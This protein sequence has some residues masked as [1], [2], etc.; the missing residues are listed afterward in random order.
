MNQ[1]SRSNGLFVLA[2]GRKLLVCGS[3]FKLN[4]PPVIRVHVEYG[5]LVNTAWRRNEI[6]TV[7]TGPPLTY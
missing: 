6:R 4:F 7:H 3:Q 1:V 5:N 2:Y